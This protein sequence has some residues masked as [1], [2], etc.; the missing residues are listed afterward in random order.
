MECVMKKSILEG[1][2]AGLF[3][4][5]GGAVYLSCEN[6][7]VGAVL[8]SV[9]LLSICLIGLQLFTGKV[10]MIVWSHTK[11]DWISLIGCLVGNALGTFAGSVIVGIARPSLVD[12]SAGLVSNKLA[13]ESVVT[14]FCAGVLC[15]VLMYTAVW[16]YKQK[17]TLSAIFFCVPVFILSGF[18]HSIADMFYFFLARSFTLE[19]WI[20]LGIV[21]IGNSVGGMLVPLLTKWAK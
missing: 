14:V 15:G 9:A 12:V 21:V 10:G 1:T 4:S 11:A 18:E 20:F 8:F 5:I 7:V 16:C 2:A 3:I 13:I 17:N 6:K 19:S